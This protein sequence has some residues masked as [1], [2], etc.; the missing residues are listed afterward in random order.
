[1]AI[2]RAFTINTLKI[3]WLPVIDRVNQ[4]IAASVYKFINNL[5]PAY[6][7]DIFV[8]SE[9]TTRSSNESNLLNPFR[10]NEYGKNYLSYLGAT[11][12][13]S[14]PGIIRDVNTC[15]TFKHKIK[16]KYFKY[17]KEDENSI[18]NAN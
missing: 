1:M 13:N 7:A 2:K 4:F 16:V 9:R 17:I 11:V 18:Y 12:W 8:K 15:N 6:M 5:A 3:N 10:V 14:I